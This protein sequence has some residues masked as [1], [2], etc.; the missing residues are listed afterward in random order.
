MI[1][2]IDSITGFSGVSLA[3]SSRAWGYAPLPAMKASEGL[4]ETIDGLL[5]KSGKAPAD[6]SGVMALSGPGSFTGLRVGLSVA[7]AFA[8]GLGLPA[9]ALPAAQ[10][11]ACGIEE[12]DWIY[13]QSLNP[14][15]LYAVGFGQFSKAFQGTIGVGE[16]SAVRQ[17]SGMLSSEHRQALSSSAPELKLALP[18]EEIWQKAVERHFGEA[19]AGQPLEPF[20]LKAPKITVAKKA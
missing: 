11:W 19:K 9:L 13:L 20:Y 14:A 2:C 18:P 4:V 17:W 16:L 15:E 12:K 5:K 3:D 1:L 10:W 6:L 7:N 8:Y